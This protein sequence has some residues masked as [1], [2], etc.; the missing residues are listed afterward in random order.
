MDTQAERIKKRRAELGLTQKEVAAIA[1]VSRVAVTQWE[2]DPTVEIKGRNL[3]G[4]AKALQC[5]S[6]YIL[7]GGALRAEDSRGEYRIT[8][9]VSPGPDLAGMA[10]E[11]SW[12]QAGAWAEIC[13]ADP[14][15]EAVTWHHRVAGG[16]QTFVL[17][18]VGESMLPDYPPG[19]L[20][21]VDPD[22]SPKSGDDVIAVLTDTDEATF[23][24]LVEEPGSGRMLKALNPA[25][26]DPYLPINGNCRI[27]G[28]VVADMRLR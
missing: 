21:F 24:R 18:V 27:V 25:W 14:D 3:E 1:G 8:S 19:R 17:R 2:S 7:S 28:V 12:V 20:I 15:P 11:L 6:R 22:R 23:K 9:N 10:P 26:H 5:S 4:L 13:Q 16:E